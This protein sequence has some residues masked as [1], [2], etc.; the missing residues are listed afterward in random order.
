MQEQN[1][2]KTPYQ[3][4]IV[5][6]HVLLSYNTFFSQ[7]HYLYETGTVPHDARARA[8]VEVKV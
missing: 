4:Y 2:Q 3:D 1:F 8:K 7:N 5:N 6:A